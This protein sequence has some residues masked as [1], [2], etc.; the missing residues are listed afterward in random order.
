LYRDITVADNG[1]LSLPAATMPHV[2]AIVTV[3]T[4]STQYMKQQDVEIDSC[5]I[6]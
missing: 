3:W 5:Q 6:K 4:T 1:H 2:W